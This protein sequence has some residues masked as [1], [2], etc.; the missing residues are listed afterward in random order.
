MLPTRLTS[1][2]F[3]REVRNCLNLHYQHNLYTCAGYGKKTIMQI[4]RETIAI[5]Q[6]AYRLAEILGVPDVAVRTNLSIRSSDSRQRDALI[7]A[8]GHSFVLEWKGSGSLSHVVAA[9]HRLARARLSFSHDVIPLLAVPYMGRA[10]QEHCAKANVSWLDLSGNARIIAPGIFYQ[11]LGN[12]NHYRRAGRPETA[13]GPRGSRITRRLLIEPAMVVRQRT[14]AADTGLDEGHTSRVVGKLL[15]TG[16]VERGQDGIRVTDPEALLDAWRED[17]RF[18][19]HH[20]LR[21]HIAARSGD[22]LTHSIAETLSKTEEPF[23][24]TALP[25]AWLRTHYA[26]FRL[27]TVYLQIPPTAGLKKDLGFREEER[28]ANTWLVV[29]N[30]E[31]VFDGVEVIDGIP[32]VHPVQAYIDL[33]DHPER[34]GEAA[35]EIH[36]QLFLRNYDGA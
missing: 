6:A 22:A 10:A 18:D 24:A 30:D 29:P 21:G 8:R 9:I 5:R 3:P 20:V 36:K 17:Y 14:L 4:P 25:A 13:F 12:P 7:Y 33:K 34:A 2:A 19:R 15:E 32:C 27:S 1:N 26:G 31:G 35:T 11:N 23:A 16:L 28:G